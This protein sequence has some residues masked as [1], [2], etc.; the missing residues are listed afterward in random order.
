MGSRK[1]TVRGRALSQ[2]TVNDVLSYKWGPSYVS[3]MASTSLM[4]RRRRIW[5]YHDYVGIGDTDF[6]LEELGRHWHLD[7]PKRPIRECIRTAYTEED[8]EGT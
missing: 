5:T 7:D 3:G 8:P 4:Y 6:L 2:P 1:R